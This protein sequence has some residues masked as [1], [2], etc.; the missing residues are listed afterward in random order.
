MDL[1]WLSFFYSVL[2]FKFLG[3]AEVCT[4]VSALELVYVSAGINIH[5][6]LE[7]HV[8]LLLLIAVS[9]LNQFQ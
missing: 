8:S 5:V 1:G 7:K 9:S 2:N 6:G 4:L 3:L